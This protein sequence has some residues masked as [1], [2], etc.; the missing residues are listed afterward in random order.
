ML[1]IEEF[2][3][4]AAH[5][6]LNSK[7]LEETVN[8]FGSF[9][10]MVTNKPISCVTFFLA[11]EKS[12]EIRTCIQQISDVS[13]FELVDYLAKR[14]PVLNKSKKIKYETDLPQF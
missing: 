9:L 2:A 11:L 6:I 14:Y 3:H 4:P 13:W 10:T 8:C 5:Q 1:I 7:E 12:P